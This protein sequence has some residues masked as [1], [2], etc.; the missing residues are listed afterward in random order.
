MMRT[1]TA[2]AMLTIFVAAAAA[3]V[4]IPFRDGTVV[5]AVDYTVTGSYVMIEMA[6]GAKVAYD[7]ADI[8]LGAL[9]AAEAAAAGDAKP[10]ADQPVVT[11]GRTGALQVPDAEPEPSSGITITDQHVKH[12]RG[13]G[14]A[15]AED[16][17]EESGETADEN[18]PPEGY[19]QGGN[20]LLNNVSVKPLEGGQWE[21][22]G[23]V[24]NRTKATVLDVRANMEASV[25]DGDPWSASAPV[26]GALAPDGKAS[27]SHVFSAPSGAADDWKPAV[28]V[29]LVWMSEETR[30]EP[31]YD[32]TAPHPSALPKDRGSVGGADV[33]EGPEEPIQ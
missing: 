16:E 14:I 8:D 24:V 22:R 27:F 26:S 10:A 7:V 31:N 23:E 32:R 12:V 1:F 17:G 20:V 4:E 11:L 9:R 29:N 28:R 6:N 25:P 30:V 3:A 33:V 15:G 13:S 21:V 2:A 5:E 18:A 19:E